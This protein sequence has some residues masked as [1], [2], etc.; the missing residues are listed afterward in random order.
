EAAYAARLPGDFVF[1]TLVFTAF[2]TSFY[3]WRLMF[4]TFHGKTRA[5]PEVYKHAHE[6]P[7]VMRIPLF[8]LAVGAVAAG[9]VFAPYFIGDL[10][11]EFWGKA[12][13]TSPSNHILHDMH[14]VDE[15]V[16]W[17]PFVAMA[18]G[19]ALSWIYYIRA[20]W[21]PAATA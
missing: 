10:Y 20:P 9:F 16:F 5:E 8:V 1:W 19:F 15:W 4:M 18:S 6:S 14:E 7:W 13:F 12:L 21:L 3:S 2:L 11:N 17:A